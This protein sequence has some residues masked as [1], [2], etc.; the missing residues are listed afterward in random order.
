[1]PWS[2]P[3]DLYCERTDPSF[4]AEPVN[5]LTNAAFLIAA[6]L[7]LLE[8]QRGTRRDLAL[9]ALIGVVALVGLGSFLFHTIAT[10]G[11][12]LF[13]I[14]PIAVFIYGYFFLALRRFLGLRTLPALAVF[15]GFVIASNATSWAVPASAL[16]G[17][18]SYV[19]ALAALAVVGWLI[20]HQAEGKPVL[21]AAALF[22]ISVGLRSVDLLV[23][24][25]FPLGTHFLWHT[26]NAVVLYL[27]LHAGMTATRDRVM[28]Q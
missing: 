16:N 20:R 25:A 5:A 26:L 21:L 14:I 12:V 9:L 28:P 7:A 6:L 10:R 13:D 2:T 17:S 8:W 19:P 24:D 4:W 27:L 3:V 18:A 1:M 15:V 23:C 22:T 11:A